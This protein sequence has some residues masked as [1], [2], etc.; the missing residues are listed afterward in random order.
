[1]GNWRTVNI[2]GTVDKEEVNQLITA[3]TPKSDYS[4]FHPLSILRGLCGL[5]CWVKEHI[6]AR[7]NLAERGYSVEIVA[8]T[9]KSLVKVAPSL[10]VKVHCGDNYES[11]NCI[12]TITVED[13]KVSVGSPEVKFVSGASEDEV[14]GRLF[15]AIKR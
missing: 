1:M 6:N 9:L 11:E 14:T 12:A 15:K 7:G 10:N 4:N 13:G 3:C 8:K 5:G 2:I